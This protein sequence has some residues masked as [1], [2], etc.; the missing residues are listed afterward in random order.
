M[1]EVIEGQ[2]TYLATLT[3]KLLRTAKLEG[4]A[5]LFQPRTI[6]LRVLLEHALAGLR[7]QHDVERILVA[8]EEGA[9]TLEADPE[10]LEMA[11]VQVLE[12]ALKYSPDGT[13]VTL[14]SRSSAKELTISIHNEGPPIPEREQSLIFERYFRSPSIEHRASGTGVGLSVA[15]RA[16][17]AHGGQ[18]R[19]E[20]NLAHGT[21]FTVRLPA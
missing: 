4:G 9:S 18:I 2:A 14:Q 7:S 3:D 15:K 1:A 12:N 19:V 17:E 10:L 6:D 5:R 16:I 13:R 11:L 8:V 20:S 21:T